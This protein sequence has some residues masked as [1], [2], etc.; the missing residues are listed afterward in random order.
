MTPNVTTAVIVLKTL[1]L[2]LGGSITFYAFKAYRRTASSALRALALGFGTVTLGALL[3][4]IVDQLLPLD[5]NLAL[6][7]E[8]LF[9]TVGFGI[10][11]YSLY[12][13]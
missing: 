8:S 4:G 9:T 10:I 11:L 6:V 7:V 12:V 3:A 1:T 13:E 2:V 5:P